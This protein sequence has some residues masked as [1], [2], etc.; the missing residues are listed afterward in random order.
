[1]S[2]VTEVKTKVSMNLFLLAVAVFLFAAI[3]GVAGGNQ[4]VF[5]I[6]FLITLAVVLTGA[7]VKAI[8]RRGS[9]ENAS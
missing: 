9:E 6:G 7:V 3:V 8:E 4:A 2:V 1:M 5:L